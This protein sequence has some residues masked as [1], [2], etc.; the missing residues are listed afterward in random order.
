MYL[1]LGLQRLADRIDHMGLVVVLGERLNPSATR[2]FTANRP[3]LHRL[4]LSSRRPGVNVAIERLPTGSFAAR[5]THNATLSARLKIPNFGRPF[6][7]IKLVVR[8]RYLRRDRYLPL[9]YH[10]S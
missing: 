9:S 1:G 5:K 2:R 6:I 4:R 7:S 8:I 10:M 3:N